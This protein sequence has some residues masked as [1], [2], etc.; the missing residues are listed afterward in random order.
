MA[1]LVSRSI[2]LRFPCDSLAPKQYT[3]PIDC[4]QTEDARRGAGA[5]GMSGERG[6]YVSYLLRLWQEQTRGELVWRASLE[7]SG[8]RE[9]QG[10]AR[11]GDLFNFLEET[12][13]LM[14]GEKPSSH[15]AER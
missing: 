7:H 3:N 10:F 6:P 11:L 14:D 2:S 8:T 5:D 13:A 15:P 4:M 12:C 9:R 1:A